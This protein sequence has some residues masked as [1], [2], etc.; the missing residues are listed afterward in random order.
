MNHQLKFVAFLTVVGKPVFK[1][2]N[3][4]FDLDFPRNPVVSKEAPFSKFIIKN[5]C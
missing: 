4:T 1:V 2:G 5:T 3:S